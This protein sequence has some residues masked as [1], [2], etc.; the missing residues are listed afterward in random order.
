MPAGLGAAVVEP[1][2]PLLLKLPCRGACR[3]R[4]LPEPTPRSAACWTLRS[5]SGASAASSRTRAA[6]RSPS[7]A[8]GRSS[9]WA[10]RVAVP[11]QA[12]VGA[13]CIS[14]A[15]PAPW[16][17]FRCRQAVR[18]PPAHRHSLGHGGVAVFQ[19]RS[20]HVKEVGPC[21]A[22]P[23]QVGIGALHALAGG[24]A[25]A[26]SLVQ[27]GS[28]CAPCMLGGQARGFLGLSIAQ[29]RSRRVGSRRGGPTLG[30]RPGVQGY[31]GPLARGCTVVT[32][33]Q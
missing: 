27:A 1:A 19:Q 22:L 29:Q 2:H 20:V 32:R 26:G 8:V 14:R 7:S 12:G 28:G 16:P 33:S 15:V 30:R 10:H 11:R 25:H 5:S 4:W 24:V 31:T 3:S 23:R 21:A 13:H 9:R 18:S 17:A 6:A